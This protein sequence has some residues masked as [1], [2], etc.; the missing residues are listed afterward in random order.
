MHTPPPDRLKI[1]MMGADGTPATPSGLKRS[2][3]PAS[4]CNHNVG[5]GKSN[6]FELVTKGQRVTSYLPT[7]G[8]EFGCKLIT[9]PGSHPPSV[10]KIQ[11]WV[12]SP[13]VSRMCVSADFVLRSFFVLSSFFFP[14]LFGQDT[15]GQERFRN[16][17]LAYFRAT[18]AFVM[19]YNVENAQ[20]L[21]DLQHWWMPRV[22]QR[23][24]P[25]HIPPIV[26]G[27]RPAPFLPFITD[28]R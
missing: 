23:F 3:S 11:I 14:W 28:R 24:D 21:A 9:L 10:M 27:T 2:N 8:V 16:I 7:I 18:N 22:R 15:G 25:P 5:V 12:S 17:C 20:S 6:L 13:L 1:V 19:V 26:L 4:E